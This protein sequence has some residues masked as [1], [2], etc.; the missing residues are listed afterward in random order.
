MAAMI[1]L[2]VHHPVSSQGRLAVIAVMTVSTV[3]F[4]TAVARHFMRRPH[5]GGV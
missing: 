4:A 5:R 3:S 1:T 2:L